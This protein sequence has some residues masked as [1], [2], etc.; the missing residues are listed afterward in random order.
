MWHRWSLIIVRKMLSQTGSIELYLT[1]RCGQRILRWVLIELYQ[2]SRDLWP[3]RV[4]GYDVISLLLYL[5]PA[6]HILHTGCFKSEFY[7]VFNGPAT[8]IL[9]KHSQSV[10]YHANY[11]VIALGLAYRLN[12]FFF[13]KDQVILSAEYVRPDII[14]FEF[15]IHWQNYV[16]EETFV[17]H[18]GMLG[19]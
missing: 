8:G 18:P 15:G 16:S 1:C 10:S 3:I 11:L 6:N 17:F 5:F 13:G 2:A 14:F 12:A 7:Q 9:F 19:K 4:G